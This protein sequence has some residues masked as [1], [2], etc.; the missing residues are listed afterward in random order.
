MRKIN[1]IFYFGLLLLFIPGL[2]SAAEGTRRLGLF[3]GS[4]NG[5]RDRVTLRYAVS[6]AR[7]VSKV[8]SSMGGISDEDNVILIEPTVAEINR[9]LSNL[10]KIANQ[11]RKNSQRTELV[12]YYSGHS[13][14]KGILL[15]RINYGYRELRDQINTVQADMKIIILDSCSSGAITRVK[16]G[17]KTQPFLFDS[18][19]SASGYAFL[20]SSS[21]EEASQE[22]DTI[23]SSYFTHSILAGLRG[24][25]DSVGDGRVTLN[26]LYRYAYTETLAKTEASVYGLQHPS[27]DIQISGSGDVVLT[28]IKEISA[29][30]LISE[31]ISGRVS[32]RDKDDFLIAE[33]TKASGKPMILGLE[34]GSYQITLQQGNNFYR[35][36]IELFGNRQVT[37]GLKDFSM[38]AAAQGGARRGPAPADEAENENNVKF[39]LQ[40]WPG[41]NI[42][43][44]NGEEVTNNF[45]FGIFMAQGH[46]LEGFGL[47][48]IG[49][50]NTGYVKGAQVSSIFNY[51]HELNGFQ[52]ALVNINRG[53]EGSKGVQLGL[54]NMS[55]SPDV[56]TIGIVNIVKNGIF[57]PAIYVDDMLFTNISLRTGGKGFYSLI[58][59]GTKTDTFFDSSEDKYLVTRFGFG[60][61]YAIKN[62]FINIDASGGSLF[63]L[64][65]A[66]DNYDIN[67]D[68]E[69]YSTDTAQLRLT[70]GY[71]ILPH[72]GIFGGISYDFFYRNKSTSPD[73]R[74]FAGPMLEASFK[75]SIHKFGFF[76]GIQF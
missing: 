26:E 59:F 51:A 14:E 2:L 60:Y 58:S 36:E 43:G 31:E 3:I 71:K 52:T 67:D 17:V 1:S 50:I 68:D 45:I 73:P 53:N 28:D 69:Y 38:I 21:D 10:G 13:D 37:L 23:G 9:Q 16:G 57:H 25:A 33:L 65:D 35:S 44:K 32:I 72:L 54:F 61:E 5:G 29:S 18:S 27:Y 19:V 63:N 62:F 8:F 74:D 15:N 55:D 66:K 48:S 70:A 49:L 30:L 24:A 40:V 47:A 22:S 46:N 41:V 20:T 64:S 6:D 34:P 75:K 11:A 39:N 42:L 76:G 12:F 7:S 56:V 4:N